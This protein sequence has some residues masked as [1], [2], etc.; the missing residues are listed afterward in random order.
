MGWGEKRHYLKNTVC[1]S[2]ARPS[3]EMQIECSLDIAQ[4]RSITN[5][6][7]GLNG[8]LLGVPERARI[9]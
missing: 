6:K 2:E 5:E 1:F 7:S 4:A 8:Y 3:D 9:E